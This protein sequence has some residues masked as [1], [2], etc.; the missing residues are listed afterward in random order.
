METKKMILILN[1][2]K[3]SA[4]IAF[5]FEIETLI[6]QFGDAPFSQEQL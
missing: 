2:V 6:R 1:V 3:H 5:Y 4:L